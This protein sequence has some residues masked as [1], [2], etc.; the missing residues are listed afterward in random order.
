LFQL[1]VGVTVV[2]IGFHFCNTETSSVYCIIAFSN[3]YTT[4]YVFSVGVH[5][6]CSAIVRSASLPVPTVPTAEHSRRARSPAVP[7]AEHSRRSLAA[8]A[9]RRRCR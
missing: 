1:F 9:V 7:A 6:F 3:I 4:A 2:F 5:I 8:P